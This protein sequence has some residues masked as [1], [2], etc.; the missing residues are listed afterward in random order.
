MKN[1]DWWE[2][3]RFGMF[4]HFG[5]YAAT[6]GAWDGEEVPTLVEWIQF[7]KQI[8]LEQYSKLAGE[9]TLEKFDPAKYAALA[10]AAGMKYVVLTAKHHDGFAMYDSAYSSYNVVKMTPSHRD[11]LRELADEVRKAGLKMCVYY[12]HAL[13]WE[14]PDAFGNT[15]DYPEDKKVFRNFMDGK[16]KA[17]LQELLTGYGEIGLVWFDMPRGM[18][19]EE[20]REIKAWVEKFQPNCIVSGRVHMD[21]T[22]GD[23]GSMGDNEFPSGKLTGHWETPATLNNKWGYSAYDHNWKSPGEL[24]C[25][26]I[27][28]LSK[29]MNYLLNIGPMPDGDIPQESVEILTEMGKWVHKNA[30]AVYGTHATPYEFDFPWGRISQKGNRLYLY[31]FEHMD[32]LIL[33]GIENEVKNVYLIAQEGRKTAGFEAVE[34]D[35]AR[36]LKI[37]LPASENEYYDVVC[38][39]LFGAPEVKQGLFELPDGSI[40]LYSHM[41]ALHKLK[42]ITSC[43]SSLDGQEAAV[44]AEKNNLLLDTEF[45]VD[46]NGNIIN[47]VD[48]ENYASWNFEMYHSG[49]YEVFVQTRSAKY[50]QWEGG[51]EVEAVCAAGKASAVLNGGEKV[52]NA[53]SRYFDERLSLIGTVELQKGQNHLELH[54]IKCSQKEKAGLLVTRMLLRRV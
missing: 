7:R 12:S 47:W 50:Q 21:Q 9:L 22:I 42:N 3:A 25:L 46:P 4:I 41:A 23:Y 51:H 27:E 30:E 18:S 34:E 48:P 1:L 53:H 36:L 28:L 14:D 24:L 37:K 52:T 15:W 43:G 5:I 6:Q 10:K 35:G 8:P 26:L 45:C 11:V 38:I 16:C 32:E 13:D 17:Q 19:V 49:S 44:E 54:L 2:Q 20:S 33:P 31:L 29:G 39:E 40:S